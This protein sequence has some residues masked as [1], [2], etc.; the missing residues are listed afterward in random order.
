M[1]NNQILFCIS[2]VLISAIFIITG[3]YLKKYPPK[4]INYFYGYRSKRALKNQ[5][6]W[7]FSQQKS[8]VELIRTGKLLLISQVFIFFI[9]EEHLYTPY[10]LGVIV[11]LI[12]LGYF[13]VVLKT[14][15]AIIRKFNK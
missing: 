9:P 2:I 7:N 12:M 1:N 6:Q 3:F 5:E 14:E 4:E 10:I 11:V 8:A 13:N 15:K